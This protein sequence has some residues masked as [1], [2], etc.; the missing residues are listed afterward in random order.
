MRRLVQM[1][2]VAL[3]VVGIAL[4]GLS[5]WR[6]MTAPPDA[7][8]EGT[9]E[10]PDEDDEPVTDLLVGEHFEHVRALDIDVYAEFKG[11]VRGEGTVDIRA[12]QGMRVAVLKIHH[13]AGE[14][15]DKGEPLITLNGDE[16]RANIEKAREEGREDDVKRFTSYLDSE[17]LRA[18]VDGQVLEI[19]TDIGQVPFDQGIP[20]M[21]L[22]DRSSWSFVVMLPEDV[23]RASAPIGAQLS[24]VLDADVGTVVGTV[25][26]HGD[27][28]TGKIEAIGGYVN[29]ILGLPEHEGVEQDLTG[30]VRVPTSKQAA[31]LVPKR[32]VEW[33]GDVPIVRIWED[34]A[35]QE[36]TLRV[37]REEGD[38]YVVLYGVGVDDRIVVPGPAQ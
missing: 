15:V 33:R 28:T 1:W 8:P 38:D 36:R 4:L 3:G 17:V 13:E 19:Y 31:A 23:M 11:R 24:I 26:S 9:Y 6:V 12:P 29:V 25:N 5:A 27:T 16:V 14:F 35:I 2:P 18:P 21:T 32:A 30:V 37:D 34:G 10:E 22:A 20:L 7:D